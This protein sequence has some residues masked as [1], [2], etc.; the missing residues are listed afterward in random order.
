MEAADSWVN[1]KSDLSTV[2]STAAI[3][4][5]AKDR[6]D[7]YSGVGELPMVGE[8]AGSSINDEF[9]P[10]HFL[11]SNLPRVFEPEDHQDIS[12]L[13]YFLAGCVG[14]P[15]STIGIL[16]VRRSCIALKIGTQFGK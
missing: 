14:M 2:H 16:A 6:V 13:R 4:Y 10:G 12:C 11:V 15:S 3:A 7:D 8:A 5:G 1:S 9:M